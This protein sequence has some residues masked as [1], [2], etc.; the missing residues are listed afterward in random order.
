MRYL[1][2][3]S[4]AI[5][6]RDGD[7]AIIDRADAL[8]GGTAISMLTRVELESGV[9]RDAV[10]VAAR[11]TALDLFLRGVPSLELTVADVDAYARIVASAT[12]SRRKILDRVIAAQAMQRNLWLVTLN[13]SDFADVPGLKLENWG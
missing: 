8:D 3:T 6:L 9:Y 4:V 2:D 11:R 12:Y 10:N 5:L 1:L 13:A 7:P